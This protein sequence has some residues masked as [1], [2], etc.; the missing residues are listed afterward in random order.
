MMHDAVLIC[1]G[2]I[3]RYRVNVFIVS[4]EFLK[5]ERAIF[6][7]IL[8]LFWKDSCNSTINNRYSK[9]QQK[10]LIQKYQILI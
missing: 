6:Q 2:A 9:Q 4:I 3:N 5:L 8:K 10:S 1:N 7:V